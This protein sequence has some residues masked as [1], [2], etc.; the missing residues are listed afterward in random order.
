MTAKHD[1]TPAGRAGMG[2]QRPIRASRELN[3]SA[4]LPRHHARAQPDGRRPNGEA[5]L[6]V[7]GRWWC[8]VRHDRVTWRP[9]ARRGFWCWGHRHVQ[10]LPT[11]RARLPE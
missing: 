1:L 3:L 7:V 4:A 6:R 8:G 5:L 10:L 11:K 2:E 9:W